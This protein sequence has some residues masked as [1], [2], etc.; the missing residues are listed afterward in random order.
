[1]E[2]IRNLGEVFK[3]FRTGR[4]IS[5]KQIADDN[6]S[7]SQLSRFERGESE[8]SASKFMAALENMHVEVG[9]FMDVVR[10]HKRTDTI[11]FMSK[12]VA[13]EYKRDTEG[14]MKLYDEQKEK[15]EKKPSEYQ[16]HLNMILAKSFICKCSPEI[17]FPKEYVDEIS[18]Y[19]FSVEEW[20]IYE[21]IIIGNLYLF[22]DIPQLH[23]MGQE[24]INRYAKAGATRGLA[25]ITLLN[26]YETC[27]YRDD[28]KTA[29][30]YKERIPELLSDETLLYER[31]IYLFL[32]GLY[33]YKSG[34]KKEGL[35]MMERSI[36]IYEGLNCPNL[37]NNY[38]NDMKRFIE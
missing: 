35:A 16:Y 19:L 12:L 25:K 20:K 5:L 9:E 26:I 30:F 22:I 31:N 21:L 13:L 4:N 1:M 36:S 23:M 10:G 37:A 15:Y 27:V 38:R 34:D 11:E 8:L 7:L 24:I 18:D 17:P 14:F 3:E 28:L 33:T 29:A 6:V 32:T 2:K